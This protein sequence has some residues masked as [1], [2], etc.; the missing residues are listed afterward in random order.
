MG[1]INR[2]TFLLHTGHWLALTALAPGLSGCARLLRWSESQGRYVEDEPG[3]TAASGPSSTGTSVTAGADGQGSSTTTASIALGGG[4]TT[5]TSTA[6][7]SGC[8]R[9]GGHPRRFA[10]RNVR[11]PW[12]RSAAW[13][14]S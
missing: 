8:S 7:P 10:R 14:G 11:P 1:D 6:A 4:S 5:A 9:P 12:L 2:R 13:S 3:D